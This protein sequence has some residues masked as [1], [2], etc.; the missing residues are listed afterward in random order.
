MAL[1]LP[2]HVFHRFRRRTQLLFQQHVARFVQHAILTRS[3]AQIQT[4]RQLLLANI[5]SLFCRYG[6]N[7]HSSPVFFISCA[8]ERVDNLGAYRIPPETGLLI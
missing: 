1:H 4:N 3:I 8:F 5:L 2:E 7:L 6:A